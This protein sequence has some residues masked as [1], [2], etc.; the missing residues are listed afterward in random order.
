MEIFTAALVL[1]GNVWVWRVFTENLLFF[2]LLIFSSI[3]LVLSFKL[4]KK[5][6]K[7]LFLVILFLLSMIQIRTTNIRSLT[8]LANEDIRVKDMRLREY[9]PVY[10]SLGGKTMWIPVAHWLEDRPESIAF[11]RILG[12]MSQS[13]DPNYYFFANHPREKIELLNFEK[14][15]FIMF[16]F[17]IIG[18]LKLVE[19]RYYFSFIFA[20][21]VPIFI[22]S[23]IGVDNRM[24]PFIVFPFIFLATFVGLRDA[25]EYLEVNHPSR[26]KLIGSI[27]I[28]F[29]VLNLIQIV[30]YQIY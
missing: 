9:P 22:L 24:G 18:T 7:M 16:P 1:F 19:K 29:F 27:F 4:K 3:F 8:I 10:L 2:V 5:K 26:M 14:F 15:P 13:I 21:L 28:I 20:F 17:F 25:R 30:S 11:F 23:I 12:N 6:P